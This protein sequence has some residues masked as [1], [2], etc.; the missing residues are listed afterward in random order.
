VLRAVSSPEMKAR[1]LP[2]ARKAPHQCVGQGVQLL[3][4]SSK[5]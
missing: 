4:V 5:R 1:R 3:G 2:D